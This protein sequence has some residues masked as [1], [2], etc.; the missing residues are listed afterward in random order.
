MVESPYKDSVDWSK[1]LIFW[2]YERV[3]PL[4]SDDSNYK[5][6]WDGF[7]QRYAKF[8]DIFGL[9]I[10]FITVRVILLVETQLL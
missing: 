1:W 6:A 4:N 2:E 7:L 5:L 9:K 10:E 8:R 3:V